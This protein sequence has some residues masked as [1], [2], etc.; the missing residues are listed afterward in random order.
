M[1]L[2]IAD[3]PYLGRADRW[4]G[5]GRGD[6]GGRGRAD[7][8][9]DAAAWDAPGRHVELVHELVANYDGWALAA[10]PASLA[11]YLDAAPDDVRVMVWHRRNAPPSGARMRAAWEPVIAYVP[12]ARRAHGTGPARDDVLDHPAGRP[13]FAGA[14]PPA[15]TRWVLDALG[16]DPHTD[17]VA[18]LFPGSGAVTAE[19][20]QGV[21]RL[22]DVTS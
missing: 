16:Y 14:K 5:T 18:D 7:T 20:R 19:A 12:L 4:Y 9:P 2:A 3:P 22:E 11:L 8:H 21:L 13:G 10:A 6:R 15:W 1:R 17:E